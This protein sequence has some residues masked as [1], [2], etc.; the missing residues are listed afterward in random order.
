MSTETSV[1]QYLPLE[2]IFD[3]WRRFLIPIYQR[4]YSWQ[5]D[6]W[7]DLWDDIYYLGEKTTHFTGQISVAKHKENTYHVVDGQQRLTTLIILVKTLFDS[8]ED[9]EEVD[10]KFKSDWEKNILC[11]TNAV[12]GKTDCIFGYEKNDPSHEFF[13]TEILNIDETSK[14]GEEDKNS[15]YNHNLKKARE[16]FEERFKYMEMDD[17]ENEIGKRTFFQRLVKKL[18]FNFFVLP[19]EIN[20]NIVFDTMNNRGL[21][22]SE[23]EKLKNRLFYI[24]HC[25]NLGLDDDIQNTYIELYRWLGKNKNLGLEDDDFLRIHTTI[26]YD[27][28]GKRRDYIHKVIYSIENLR[29]GEF[30][31]SKNG[32]ENLKD[33][34]DSLK[35]CIPHYYEMYA[36]EKADEEERKWWNSLERLDKREKGLG[37]IAPLVLALWTEEKDSNKRADF[38]KTLERF[39]FLR[40]LSS[41]ADY[42][43]NENEKRAHRLYMEGDEPSVVMREIDEEI[44]AKIKRD[45]ESVL[46][47][48]VK[49]YDGNRDDIWYLLYEWD[50]HTRP[51]GINYDGVIAGKNHIEHIYPQYPNSEW[52]DSGINFE[53]RDYPELIHHIGNLVLLT[54][55][56]NWQVENKSFDKKKEI[57]KN[58][59]LGA[60]Y[61]ADRYEN[62]N[63]QAIYHRGKELLEFFIDRWE[64]DTKPSN[65]MLDNV[66][67]K[68]E[69]HA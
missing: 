20:K 65:E 67:K 39:T 11:T 68:E 8:L 28:T 41:R 38:L 25:E 53:D 66:L 24:S 14:I 61:I 42:M 7:I 19:N 47:N 32:Y 46:I 40:N 18:M 49:G 23:M 2:K 37:R 64:V 3:G 33:Y 30:S 60:R 63:N 50:I 31:E 5:Q 58:D 16:F 12:T 35:E 45:L 29:N 9:K 52:K 36:R 17:K 56:G 22:L 4:G 59:T 69:L 26:Y 27:V 10:E 51:E 55:N 1:V 15:L 34:I 57:Y 6:H 21:G 13:K 44:N 43:E 48:L 54:Q 62:W